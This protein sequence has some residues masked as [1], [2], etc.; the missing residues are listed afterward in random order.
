MTRT[1][2]RETIFT[3]IDFESAGTASGK[4]DA[5]VQ[6]GTTSWSLDDGISDTWTSYIHTDQDITWSAQKVHGITRD[7]LKD[8]PKLMLL[9]PHLKRRL[10]SRAVVAHGHGT[11]KR[12]LNAFPGHGFGPWI[13]TLQLSRAAWPE[14]SDHSLGAICQTHNLHHSVGKIVPDRTWHDALYDAAASIVLLEH[15]INTFELHNSPLSSL[16][17]PDTSAWHRLR[18]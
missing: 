1:V 12:F 9:W 7:D 6:V 11:E 17:S 8:A 15:I 2:I 16:I 3:A 5:P 13:D 10:A 14:I 4:T 18:R